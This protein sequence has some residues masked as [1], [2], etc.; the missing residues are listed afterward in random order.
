[1]FNTEYTKIAY[2]EKGDF[3]TLEKGATTTKIRVS[4]NGT[5]EYLP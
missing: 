2:D 4:R 1:V 5:I 3:Y